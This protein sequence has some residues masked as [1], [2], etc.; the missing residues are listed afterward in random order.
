MA[1]LMEAEDSA[2][3]TIAT[4]ELF[5]KGVFGATEDCNGE[6]WCLWGDLKIIRHLERGQCR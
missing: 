2:G 4:R 3:T 6:K 1:N 5:Q